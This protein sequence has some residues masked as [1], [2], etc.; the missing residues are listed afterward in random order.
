MDRAGYLKGLSE[1]K[2]GVETKS[3]N[4]FD[5]TPRQIRCIK[6]TH[7]YLGDGNPFT[8][9]ELEVGKLYTFTGGNAECYGNMVF[10]E[11]LPSEYGYQSY[12][13]E[14]VEPYDEAIL[15]KEQEA[16]LH[17][18]LDKGLKDTSLSL[19]KKNREAYRKLA[20]GDEEGEMQ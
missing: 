13:F 17:S 19:I 11:E 14:E 1:K 3:V 9:E 4:V 15:L 12:L 7:D 5:Q 16:W 20:G 6:K 8:E 10:L 2:S 18:I